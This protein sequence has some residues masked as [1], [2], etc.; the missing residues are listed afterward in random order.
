LDAERVG[1]TSV[2]GV[3]KCSQATRKGDVAGGQAQKEWKRLACGGE[4]VKI[5]ERERRT[6]WMMIGGVGCVVGCH[7]KSTLVREG[8]SASGYG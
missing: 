8:V 6:E 2:R 3:G 7:G 1:P 4:N 5:P